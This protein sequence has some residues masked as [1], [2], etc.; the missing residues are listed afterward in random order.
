[1]RNRSGDM[2]DALFSM[3]RV[4]RLVLNIDII[5][6][7]DIVL[8]GSSLEWDSNLLNFIIG[9]FLV[10]VVFVQFSL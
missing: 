7:A 5:I 1:M 3:N 10:C 2:V 8:L 9:I 6:K 4:G